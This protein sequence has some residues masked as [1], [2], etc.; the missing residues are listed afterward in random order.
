MMMMVFMP[1]MMIPLAMNIMTPSRTFI[2][3][4]PSKNSIPIPHLPV[5]ISPCP[6]SIPF[7]PQFFPSLLFPL[8]LLPPLSVSCSLPPTLSDAVTLPLITVCGRS[9]RPPFS[10]HT[11]THTTPP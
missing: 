5:P 10:V 9:S 7:L 3:T 6:F 8:L 2:I 4:F 11:C 1:P